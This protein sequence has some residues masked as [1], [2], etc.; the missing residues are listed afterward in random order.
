M[1]AELGIE[2]GARSLKG[3]GWIEQE[4]RFGDPLRGALNPAVSPQGV[5]G[6]VCFPPQ[7]QEDVRRWR[8]SGWE[9]VQ[10]VPKRQ[11]QDKE[12]P[13]KRISGQ[14]PR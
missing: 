11:V 6:I 7:Q 5:V 13:G 12:G 2:L 1:L 3:D 8:G 9:A 14:K 10:R 4:E